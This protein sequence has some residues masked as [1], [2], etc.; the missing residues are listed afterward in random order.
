MA[1]FTGKSTTAK[2]SAKTPAA[3]T[4]FGVKPGATKGTNTSKSKTQHAKWGK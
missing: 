2:G 4:I 3:K 1:K